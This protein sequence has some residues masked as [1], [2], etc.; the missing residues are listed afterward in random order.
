MQVTHT[1]THIRQRALAAADLDL[2]SLERRTLQRSTNRCQAA[3][4]P[5]PRGAVRDVEILLREA[6]AHGCERLGTVG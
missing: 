5:W 4:P 1:Q 6:L 3:V 2:R